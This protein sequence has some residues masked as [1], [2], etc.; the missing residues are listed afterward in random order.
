MLREFICEIARPGNVQDTG[1]REAVR[2]IW[3]GVGVGA[4]AVWKG[5]GG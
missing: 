1:N 3:R 2:N 5:E 4:G